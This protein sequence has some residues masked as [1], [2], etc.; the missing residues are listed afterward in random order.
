MAGLHHCLEMIIK[1]INYLILLI[2]NNLTDAG[3]MGDIADTVQVKTRIKPLVPPEVHLGGVVVNIVHVDTHL[4][5]LH[6]VLLHVGLHKHGL[7]PG[8]HNHPLGSVL[9]MS[10]PAD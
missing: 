7:V 6:L 5:H 4:Q 2:I 3:V 10:V 9:G 1:L 8:Y